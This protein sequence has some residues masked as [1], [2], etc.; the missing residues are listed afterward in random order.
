MIVILLPLCNSESRPRPYLVSN[1]ASLAFA[2]CTS[3]VFNLFLFCTYNAHKIKAFE[4]A[5]GSACGEAPAADRGVPSPSAQT[6]QTRSMS[7]RKRAILLP[8]SNKRLRAIH[9]AHPAVAPKRT[10]VEATE[11]AVA[12]SASNYSHINRPRWWIN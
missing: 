7:V 2:F 8:R 4:S 9:E 11:G 1:V 10:N 3:V 6:S 12:A 5:V